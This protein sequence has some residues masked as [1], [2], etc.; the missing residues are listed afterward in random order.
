M[1][2]RLR[3]FA[4]G[5]FGW[6]ARALRAIGCR[7]QITVREFED[8]RVFDVHRLVRTGPDI[9]RLSYVGS[10]ISLERALCP[11]L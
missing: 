8:G 5:D 11:Q 1:P 10:G 6:T 7:Y 9:W 2:Q 4:E 3:W